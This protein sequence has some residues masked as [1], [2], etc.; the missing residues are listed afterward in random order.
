ME[1]LQIA[2]QSAEEALSAWAQNM[3]RP[4][5]HRIDICLDR[6]QFKQAHR[7]LRQARWGYL[8]A[9]TGL[10]LPPATGTDG[11]PG[12]GQIEVLYHFCQGPA[13][14]TLR[15]TLPYSDAVIDTVC[16]LDPSATLYE[17][18]LMELFGVTITGTPNTARLVLPD[19]WPDGVYP[20]R[21]SFTGLQNDR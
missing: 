17:R 19:D 10:D 16:D 4:E 14:L 18:E 1:S 12:E 21:K 7:A 15:V 20:L 2:L 9:I 3:S 8:A 11:S 13:V 5:E 6:S